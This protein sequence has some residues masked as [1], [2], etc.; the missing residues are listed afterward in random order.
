MT[1][2]RVICPLIVIKLLIAIQP[3]PDK[4]ALRSR[5][6]D[7]VTQTLWR[8]FMIRLPSVCDAEVFGLHCQYR[9]LHHERSIS[10][11]LED[12]GVDVQIDAAIF[13]QSVDIDFRAATLSA[14]QI[15]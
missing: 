12:D 4:R 6:D 10:E 2:N 5:N 8:H 15:L 7:G 11:G 13:L 14:R 9:V 1:H 3:A